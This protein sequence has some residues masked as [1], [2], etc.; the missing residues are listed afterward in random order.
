[1]GD[2]TIHKGTNIDVPVHTLHTM[3]EYWGEDGDLFNHQR[4]IDNKNL[5]KETFYM[6]FG[7]GPRNCIGLRF[8][9]VSSH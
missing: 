7:D 9:N 8:A 3:K 6:P 1:M 2:K 4:W 5:E